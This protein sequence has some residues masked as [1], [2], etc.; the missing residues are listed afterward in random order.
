MSGISPTV[1]LTRDVLQHVLPASLAAVLF[2]PYCEVGTS[3]A[4]AKIVLFAALVGA[5]L[6]GSLLQAASSHPA[7]ETAM[8]TL[9]RLLTF[10]RKAETGQE[11]SRYWV[12]ESVREIFDGTEWSDHNWDMNAL[13]S[14]LTKEEREYFYLTRAYLELFKVTSM[15]AFV[16][17][18]LNLVWLAG[19]SAISSI[20]LE[21]NSLESLIT[22]R[23]PLFGGFS[24]PSLLVCLASTAGFAAMYNWYRTEYGS[25][26]AEWGIYSQTVRRYQITEGGLAKS[27]WGTVRQK[28]ANNPIPPTLSLSLV[29]GSTIIDVARP[30]CAGRFQFRGAYS[31]CVGTTC[32]LEVTSKSSRIAEFPLTICEK[33]IP[34][35]EVILDSVA[36]NPPAQEDGPSAAGGAGGS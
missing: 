21:L 13:F 27:I 5:Y 26:F 25:L 2:L 32:R 3:E 19:M 9:F 1:F 30:D 24:S 20:T 22:A 4:E 34:E 10:S 11:A 35:F 15:L 23:T 18:A 17:L 6:V 16:Y 7:T 28:D 33:K 36:F 8:A 12:G 31:K 29:R 14:L